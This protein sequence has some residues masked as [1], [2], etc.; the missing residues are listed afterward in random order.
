MASGLARA[1]VFVCIPA[2]PWFAVAALF[3]LMFA[4]GG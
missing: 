1:T 3:A 4:L 2:A